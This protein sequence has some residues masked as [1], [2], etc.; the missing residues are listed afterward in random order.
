MTGAIH[1]RVNAAYA[2]ARLDYLHEPLMVAA[3]LGHLVAGRDALLPPLIAAPIASLIA[4]GLSATAQHPDPA[5]TVVVRYAA[6][7][8]GTRHLARIA[9][10]VCRAGRP[11]LV[12]STVL[13]PPFIPPCPWARPPGWTHRARRTIPARA[14]CSGEVIHARAPRLV[15]GTPARLR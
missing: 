11:R 10:K 7:A 3:W 12:R 4:G 14:S 2:D 6:A 5:A 9:A 8:G 13:S 15:D 1:A